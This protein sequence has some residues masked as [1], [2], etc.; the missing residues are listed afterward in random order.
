M[1]YHSPCYKVSSRVVYAVPV[2]VISV[3][4]LERSARVAARQIQHDSCVIAN[5]AMV[6]SLQTWRYVAVRQFSLQPAQE[7]LAQG[8]REASNGPLGPVKRS[9]RS[10]KP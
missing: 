6:L 2:A 10:H 7:L 5:L 9:T 3:S 1:Y 4:T 8:R